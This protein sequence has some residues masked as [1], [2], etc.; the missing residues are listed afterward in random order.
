MARVLDGFSNRHADNI[1]PT[2]TREAGVKEAL[3]L[4]VEGDIILLTSGCIN[5]AQI[6]NGEKI[7]HSDEAIIQEFYS[8]SRELQ[9]DI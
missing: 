4:G 9:E 2:L 8:T 1:Y 7:P 5:G 6:I 3:S